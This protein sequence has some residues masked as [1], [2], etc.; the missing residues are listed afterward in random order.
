M[1]LVL[2]P[3][4]ACSSTPFRGEGS[5][6]CQNGCSGTISRMSYT[7]VWMKKI[8]WTLILVNTYDFGA[9]AND[10][11]SIGFTGGNLDCTF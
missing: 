2:L 3:Q 1:V 6:T 11:L 4:L 9:V 8:I 7:H 10:I 5:L